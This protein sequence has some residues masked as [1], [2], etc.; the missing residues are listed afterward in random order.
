M[1]EKKLTRIPLVVAN[2]QGRVQ[3]FNLVFLSERT[4]CG[5]LDWYHRTPSSLNSL[6]NDIKEGD[7]PVCGRS[8]V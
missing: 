4:N 2:E 7:N 8:G 1:K 6:E 5:F 3:I